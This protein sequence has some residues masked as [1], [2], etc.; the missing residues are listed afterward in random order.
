LPVARRYATF[1]EA[2]EENGL[3][4]IFVGFHFRKAVEEGIEHGRRIGDEAVDRV[5]LPVR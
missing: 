5:L 4:R 1:S 3:S 2:A